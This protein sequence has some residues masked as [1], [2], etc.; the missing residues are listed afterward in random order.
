MFSDRSP[1]AVT[2][3]LPKQLVFLLADTLPGGGHDV[4][5]AVLKSGELL[6]SEV[7]SSILEPLGI[8]LLRG[9]W[10]VAE[11]GA[12]AGNPVVDLS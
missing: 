2:L 4:V 3:Y 8:L 11:S 12:E 1:P 6:S 9:S 5:P 7:P 10:K